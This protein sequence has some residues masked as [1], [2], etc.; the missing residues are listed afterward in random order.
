[1]CK[2]YYKLLVLFQYDSNI[3]FIL[4]CI[5]NHALKILLTEYHEI[6]KVC[7]VSFN[8]YER[9]LNCR[10]LKFI[11][12][13]LPGQEKSSGKIKDY[14]LT[15][16]QLRTDNFPEW[17]TAAKEHGIFTISFKFYF[18]MQKVSLKSVLET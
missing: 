10:R 11:I 16:S 8:M 18:C 1:M 3:G 7:S 12:L 5:V 17:N 14:L 6:F 13:I 2:L 4:S 9:E 15:E